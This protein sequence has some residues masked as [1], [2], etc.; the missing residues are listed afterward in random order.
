MLITVRKSPSLV[1]VASLAFCACLAPNLAMPDALVDFWADDFVKRTSQPSGPGYFE[2]RQKFLAKIENARETVRRCGGCGGAQAKLDALEAEEDQYQRIAG[3]LLALTG[4]PP[5]MAR[6]LGIRTD[7]WEYNFPYPSTYE[8]GEGLINANPEW[9]KDRPPF[10]QK[11]V[12]EYLQSLKARQDA[13]RVSSVDYLNRPG[14]EFYESYRLRQAC[15]LKDYAEVERLVELGEA[16]ASGEILPEIYPVGIHQVRETGLIYY[17]DVPEDFVPPMPPAEQVVAAL[18]GGE[19]REVRVVAN[20]KQ[21]DNLIEVLITRYG[22]IHLQGGDSDACIETPREKRAE[23]L[24]RVC[25]DQS[26]MHRF[27]PYVLLC[28][29]RVT[30]NR[31][32]QGRRYGIYWYNERVELVEYEYLLNRDHGH[33][34]LVIGDARADCPATWQDSVAAMDDYQAKLATLRKQIPVTPMTVS[35][36]ESEWMVQLRQAHREGQQKHA[37]RVRRTEAYDWPGFYELKYEQ[38]AEAPRGAR[39]RA[40]RG[41]AAGESFTGECVVAQ[42]S[43]GTVLYHAAC[44]NDSRVSVGQGR[45][46][47]GYTLNLDLVP[48]NTFLL[49]DGETDTLSSDVGGARIT[50]TRKKDLFHFGEYPI[51][52]DYLLL[53]A[54]GDVYLRGLCS[55][56]NDPRDP[57]HR[58]DCI[59]DQG[60]YIWSG[61]FGRS[62]YDSA[63]L[64]NL[65][66]MLHY[67]SWDAKYNARQKVVTLGGPAIN[68]TFLVIDPKADDDTLSTAR[69]M[70]FSGGGITGSLQRIG[71]SR[72]DPA[73]ASGDASLTGLWVGEYQCGPQR[74]L[75]AEL[76]LDD[77][78]TGRFRAI[79]GTFAFSDEQYGED[80]RG[81]YAVS[82]EY[83]S[84][85]GALRLRPGE[86]IDSTNYGYN[87]LGIHA[88]AFLPEPG[89][90][91]DAAATIAG[92]VTDRAC[93][94]LQLTRVATTVP[95]PIPSSI[96]ESTGVAE[97]ESPGSA[98][99][100]PEAVAASPTIELEA[101]TFRTGEPVVIRLKELP[102]NQTDWLTLVRAN[103]SDG[104]NGEWLYTEGVK[105]GTWTFTAPRPGEY[106]VRVH[107]DYAGGNNAV[108][109]RTS[110]TVVEN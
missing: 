3:R 50:L 69:L 57:K 77:Q 49:N 11:V 4:Q 104:S 54:H 90:T 46:I 55:F 41:L 105:E 44:W 13:R 89:G 25:D 78:A 35:L 42:E 12:S 100:E 51:D 85:L 67:P 26:E 76:H 110:I 1:M 31:G 73:G 99:I 81:R 96:T 18:D 21:N 61:T 93:G 27:K 19:T 98:A 71:E 102:G 107:I 59:D 5:A 39:T 28:G 9:L 95:D 94:G 64:L 72:A 16:R 53:L 58:L 48:P 97:T 29:Y 2:Q 7:T 24:K 38:S 84:D 109:A 103:M 74:L 8:S 92:D 34:L 101:D 83:L 60:R 88:T 80:A 32:E 40:G 91:G 62:G 36:P 23:R 37:E 106:E 33:S 30:D 17:G 20:K 52:G 70:A 15:Y 47:H 45:K 43:A 66:F 14:G 6:L 87:A 65:R 108:G 22:P 82:G 10:C 86:W 63:Q 68:E 75:K 79:S 56:R